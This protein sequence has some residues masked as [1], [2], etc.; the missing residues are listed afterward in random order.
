MGNY[1]D[2][3]GLMPNRITITDRPMAV[4]ER[5]RF[6]DIE[7][8]LIMGKNHKSDLLVVVDRAS[9]LTR[10]EKLKGKDSNTIT[11]KIT[12]LMKKLPKH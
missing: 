1:K 9:L 11:K 5:K 2:T 4:E 3:R 10:I 6:G 7:V 12:Q 8:D